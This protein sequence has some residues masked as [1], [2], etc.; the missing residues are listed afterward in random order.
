MARLIE[1]FAY[2]TAR[3]RLKLDDEFPEI[4]DAILQ[5]LCPHYLAPIPSAAIVQ[6]VLDRARR[7]WRPATALPAGPRWKSPIRSSVVPLSHLLRRHALAI[8]VASCE[9][10]RRPFS[11][12]AVAGPRGGRGA[13]HR[14]AAVRPRTWPSASF[15]GLDFLRV[16]SLRR[17]PPRHALV[18]VAVEPLPADCRRQL[19]RRSRAGG[20]FS[21]H[22]RPVGF[23]PA[24]TLLPYDARS[25]PVTAAHRLLRFPAQVPLPRRARGGPPQAGRRAAVGV[26]SSS[27]ATCR[28]R[29]YVKD[30]PRL[31]CAPIVNLHSRRAEPIKLTHR[32][33]EYP[34]IP[35]A[36]NRRRWKSTRSTA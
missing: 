28:N 5:V 12:P 22:L 1:A 15:E 27:I 33:F 13:P 21:E 25:F 31:G 20:A 34:V 18:R 6:F 19:A 9:L 3:I 7:P 11:A 30:I 35:D 29:A 32:V 8:E 2:L 23:H 17:R 14:P 4:T 16:L 10:Q 26:S 36:G 24:E